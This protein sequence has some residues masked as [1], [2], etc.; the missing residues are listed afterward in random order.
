M[1]RKL[2]I[3]SFTILGLTS[4]AMAND[5]YFGVSATET[6]DKNILLDLINSGYAVTFGM[7]LDTLSGVNTAEELS[8][9]DLIDRSFLES[10]CQSKRLIF[11]SWHQLVPEKSDHLGDSEYVTAT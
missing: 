9:G 5:F 11:L 2:L 1:L 8:Y 7:K 4:T 6:E 10:V 3:Q